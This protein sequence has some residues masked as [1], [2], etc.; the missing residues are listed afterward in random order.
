MLQL[1]L[2]LIDTEEDKKK[3]VIF[4]EQYRKLMFYI[5]KEILKEDQLSEDAVQEAF[6][7]IAKNF[8]KINDVM[9]QETKAFAVIITRNVAI[10]IYNKEKKIIDINK[11]LSD[12]IALDSGNIFSKVSVEMLSD[13]ILDLPENYRDVLYLNLIYGYQFNEISS[14]LAI[15]AENVR[16]RAE[17]GRRLLQEKIKKEEF[18]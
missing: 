17:R 2:A 8:F 11:Y 1:Y 12:E 4:Y 13:Y 5:A 7:R 6:L 10:D 16:K 15:S 18:V 14:L 3:F 9:D